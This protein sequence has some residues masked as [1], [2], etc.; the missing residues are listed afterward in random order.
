VTLHD[1]QH[2]RL[3][4]RPHEPLADAGWVCLSCRGRN[5]MQ[6]DVCGS[7]GT[8]F[9]S[10]LRTEAPPVSGRVSGLAL[11][12]REAAI[13]L[14]LYVVWRLASSVSLMN[15]SGAFAR[16]RWLWNTERHLHLPSELAVQAQVLA[17]PLVVQS[18]NVFYLAA[19][20]G[21]MA[22]LLLWLFIKHREQ[23]R[24]WRNAVVAFTGVSLLAQFVSIAPPRLLPQFG[25]VDTAAVYHQSAYQGL[26][27]GL[28]DQLSTM[29]SIHVGWALI[30]ALAVISVCTSRWRWLIVV[31]P[32]LTVYAVVATANH[33]WSDAVVAAGLV[34][35][36]L[37][38]GRARTRAR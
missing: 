34:A 16:G 10:L 1:P 25:F 21:G 33:F 26:G 8:A 29:P 17:H 24:T 4:E 36:V 12:V 11:A 20:L 14:G 6:L 13:V 15:E 37:V 31:H 27:A 2:E 28:T 19:H 32:I 7:C 38:V 3:H 23:Y 18:L 35:L 9:G 5:A 22:V 30:V